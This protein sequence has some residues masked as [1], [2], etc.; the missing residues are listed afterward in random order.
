M[1]RGAGD[2]HVGDAPRAVGARPRHRARRQVPGRHRVAGPRGPRLAV[3][4]REVAPVLPRPDRREPEPRPQ[5][6]GRHLVQAPRAP[7]ARQRER[8]DH[9]AARAQRALRR[10]VEE[11]RHL[12]AVP[13]H[14]Q[15][16]LAALREV[17]DL[18]AV[19]RPLVGDVAV[20][21]ERGAD[22]LEQ[23]LPARGDAGDVLEEDEPRAVVPPGVEDEVDPVDREAV[24]RLVLRAP[25][26]LLGEEPA[27]ALA[28][29]RHEDEVGRVVAEERAQVG[30]GHLADV[31][32]VARALRELL[33]APARHRVEVDAAEAAHAALHAVERDV[34][35]DE[36][37][38]A[39]ADA[40]EEEHRGEDPLGGGRAAVHQ[41]A[42]PRRSPARPT[43][44]TVTS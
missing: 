11:H 23:L 44:H 27:E 35:V 7:L 21:A 37:E 33:E 18:A 24:E 42:S 40:R 14:H 38:G 17:A 20:G 25:A 3:E 8:L 22:L 43:C 31:A 36:A 32:T 12:A 39:D 30:A 4:R 1:P 13:R 26:L 29:R 34:R 15:E 16:P 5:A 2:A 41:T 10:L 28:R 19:V 6:D 9:V